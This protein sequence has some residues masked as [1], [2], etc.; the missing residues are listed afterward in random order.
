MP[1]AHVRT[2]SS[3]SLDSFQVI[4]T[5]PGAHATP[6]ELDFANA[7]TAEAP[8]TLAKALSAA[9]R[10]DWERPPDFDGADHWYRAQ[11]PALEPAARHELVFEGLAS[12]ADVFLDGAL[13]LHSENMFVEQRVTLPA[14]ARAGSELAICFRALKPLLSARRP[15]PRWR[16]RIVEAQQ[17]RF[18]RT[19]LLGRTGGFCPALPVVGPYRPVRI[20]AQRQ[21]ALRAVSLV[22]EQSEDGAR[23]SL[24]LT[25]EELGDA[26]GLPGAA[27]L[28]LEGA[29]GH[30]AVELR[31]GV[32]IPS[33][34]LTLSGTLEV[35]EA[36]SWWP[37][38]HGAQPQ[39]RAYVV[40][41]SLSLTDAD[42]LVI[43]LGQVGFRSLQIDREHDGLGFG[44]QLNGVPVFCRGACWTT[45]DLLTVG[46]EG[47]RETLELVRAAGMNMLRVTGITTYES[48]TFYA[49][50]DELGI[51]VF[52][53]FM[54]A[55]M[56]YPIGDSAFAA[57]VEQE[58]RAVLQRIGRRPCLTVLCG[59]SEVEQQ[60]A[61][62]GLPSDQWSSP[63]FAELLP[64]LSAELASGVP[65][66][67]SS[68]SGGNL[69][70]QVNAGVSHYYGV[71]AYHR[72]LEDARRSGVRF[73]SE[74]LA[75]ANIPAS[76]T[77]EAF[78]GELEMP[79][80]HPRW[81]QR[82]PRD[83]G[84]SWDF[85]DTRDHYVQRLFGLDPR[86]LRYADGERYLTVGSAAVGEAMTASFAEW[87]S[88]GSSCRG[89]L[90]FW[91]KD[92]WPGAGWGVIDALGVPK[93][94]YYFLKRVMQPLALLA[95]DEGLNGLLLHAVND[96][97]TP[98]EAELSLTL[99]RA[100]EAPI[101]Q[102]KSPLS[103]A[104]HSVQALSVEALLGR[105]SDSTYAYRFGPPNHD[106]I[107]ATL[108]AA[109]GEVAR[110]FHFPCG[111][112]RP[113]ELE[114]G[115]A[116]SPSE[117][118]G[119][120]GLVVTTR[121]FAQSVTLDVPGYRA[122]DDWF[123]LEPG[124]ERWIALTPTGATPPGTIR[125]SIGALNGLTRATIAPRP[126]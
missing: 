126:G 97:P 119:Q 15:R 16:T 39:S 9:R 4:S 81:K 115:L 57:N 101:E 74:C 5:A 99:Y 103:L 7:L 2:H 56:D 116:A 122:E 37:H 106:L 12:I 86:E 24:T 79:F 50:C 53:D 44:V 110:A 88:K 111:Y 14:S 55:N 95:T 100:G 26:E 91:L 107:C 80:H 94:A 114:L 104:A 76:S 1:H 17:L 42:S 61:M 33:G 45:D 38:T 59:G 125:G 65:Y 75:F 52:Q 60:A 43:D 109:S 63:L 49:L 8:C 25:L 69:P 36:Q 23:L 124:S 58:V 47:L 3:V 123:H 96:H 35:E 51:M 87:R 46:P 71:G 112:A 78:L 121:R 102:R 21:L 77:I 19:S 28:R 30:G 72:P 92:Y 66:V 82:V 67:P 10:L 11:L 54:F 89:A 68:P 20:E 117:R 40:L 18:V 113:Q 13:L 48:D 83:R 31:V 73:T 62:L 70:F 27:E 85:E 90:V 84:A 32:E 93:S 41:P 98:I 34:L 64:R 108:T 118:D 120:P 22:P 29:A 6:A 105:F